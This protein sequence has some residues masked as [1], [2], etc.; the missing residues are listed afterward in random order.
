MSIAWV[1][2]RAPDFERASDILKGLFFM[3]GFGVSS[4]LEGLYSSK[5]LLAS[6]IIVTTLPNS[7]TIVD[8]VNNAGQ[9]SL[10]TVYMRTLG[11]VLAIVAVFSIF[12]LNKVSYFIYFQF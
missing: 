11:I 1:F 6:L 9:S 4:P 10:N 12:S 2:F 5:L 3:N 8:W 7:M